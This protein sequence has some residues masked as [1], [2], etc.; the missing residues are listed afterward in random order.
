MGCGTCFYGW[1]CAM[2]IQK[3]KGHI[4]EKQSWNDQVTGWEQ[5]YERKRNTIIIAVLL[6]ILIGIALYIL[7]PH[8]VAHNEKADHYNEGLRHLEF[9]D[10]DG[11]AQE[12]FLAGDYKDAMRYCQELNYELAGKYAAAGKLTYAA[13]SYGK[14]G[15]YLDARARSFALWERFADRKVRSAQ[16]DRTAGWINADGTAGLRFKNEEDDPGDVSSWTDLVDISVD[17]RIAVGTRSDGTVVYSH[18]TGSTQLD[19]TDIMTAYYSSYHIIGLKS[20]GTVKVYPLH[21]ET[22]TME[23]TAADFFDIIAVCGSRPLFALRADGS[24]EVAECEDYSMTRD[25]DRFNSMAYIAGL[26]DV[27]AIRAWVYMGDQ[28]VVAMQADGKIYGAE[29]ET[30]AAFDELACSGYEF[31][32]PEGLQIREEPTRDRSLIAAGFSAD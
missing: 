9:G 23:K 28:R 19:W 25:P 1:G 31:W 8:W 21:S 18:E 7:M 30:G 15:D 12:F 4:M 5:A 24:L 14:A 16:A 3:G 32:I 20:D 29:G 26:K 13:I 11:A 2:I 10:P 27:V 6:M 17:S 22:C